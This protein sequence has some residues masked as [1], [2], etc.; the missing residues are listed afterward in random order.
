M[1]NNQPQINPIHIQTM[2]DS[3]A[4]QNQNLS[5]QLADANGR[6]AVL[7]TQL[8]ALTEKDKPEGELADKVV[9]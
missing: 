4:Q 3:L 2:V 1:E 9:N 8:K 5:L 6:I 7:E